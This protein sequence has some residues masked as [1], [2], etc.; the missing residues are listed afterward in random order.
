MQTHLIF[1]L[2]LF[3]GKRDRFLLASFHGQGGDRRCLT[4]PKFRYQATRLNS[5]LT[6]RIL[7]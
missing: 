2:S 3:V 5:D 4:L 7:R 6:L 1:P